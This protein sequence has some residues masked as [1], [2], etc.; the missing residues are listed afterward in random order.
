[1][2]TAQEV[3]QVSGWKSLIDKH[4]LVLVRKRPLGVYMST[5]GGL[6]GYSFGN[7]RTPDVVMDYIYVKV[8]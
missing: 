4:S 5:E 7:S 6:K 8:P 2:L 3:F 1:M